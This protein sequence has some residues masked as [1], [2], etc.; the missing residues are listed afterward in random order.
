MLLVFCYII[1]KVV[2]GIIY[3]MIGKFIG[4][5]Y[6]VMIILLISWDFDIDL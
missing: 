1:Y 3:Y 2:E 4:F 6:K 5:I